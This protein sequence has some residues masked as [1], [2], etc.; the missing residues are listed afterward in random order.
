M[1]EGFYD[2]FHHRFVDGNEFLAS[3]EPIER[4]VPTA[5][6][7]E[8]IIDE[9]EDSTRLASYCQPPL[10]CGA[11]PAG[12]VADEPLRCDRIKGHTKKIKHRNYETGYSWIS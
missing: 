6:E 9:A 10:R 11:I 2:W 8:A 5:D 7:I 12:T 3:Q 1:S 4:R